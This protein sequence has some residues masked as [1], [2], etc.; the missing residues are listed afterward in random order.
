MSSVFAGKD[1]DGDGVPDTTQ[2]DIDTVFISH[3]FFEDLDGSRDYDPLLDGAIG[4]TSHPAAVISRTAF[5]D[6]LPRYS[7][8]A[9]AG[10]LVAINASAPGADALIQVELPGRDSAS[11]SYWTGDISGR[12]LELAVPGAGAGASVTVITVADG[13]EPAV[14]LRVSADEFHAGIDT[15]AI[16]P[17]S[18]N[19]SVEMDEGDVLALLGAPGEAASAAGT[20]DG[21][22]GPP[23]LSLILVLLAGVILSGGLMMMRRASR[24]AKSP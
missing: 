20:P 21:G 12:L 8:D 13:Y 11:Y 17:G 16:R 10:S 3:G 24:R 4:A 5:P 23:W 1:V 2:E 7:A 6:R 9:F 18:L 14:A 19:S 15:G 22:S